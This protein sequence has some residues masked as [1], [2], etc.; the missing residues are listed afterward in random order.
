MTQEDKQMEVYYFNSD[1]AKKYGVNEAVFLQLFYRVVKANKSV[2]VIEDSLCWFPCA[3]KEWADYI[4]LWSYRQTDRL[5][6]S[7]LLNHTL[8]QRHFDEDERRRR[9][10]YAISNEV[11]QQLEETEL[12]VNQ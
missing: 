6:K 11:V 4:N 7:C 9:G 3:I 2:C 5:V 8:F 12:I 10:W 1:L